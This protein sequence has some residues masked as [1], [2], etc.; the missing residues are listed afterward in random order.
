MGK[1]GNIDKFVKSSKRPA[2]LFPGGL[3]PVEKK[4]VKSI[5]KRLDDKGKQ[6]HEKIF[7]SPSDA[8]TGPQYANFL[9]PGIPSAASSLIDLFPQISQA[10]GGSD[11]RE[12]RSGSRIRLTG[13][14]C[15]FWFHIPTDQPYT[16]DNATMCC[17][18]LVLSSK[19]IRKFSLLES[20]WDAGEL[21]NRKYLRDGAEDTSFLGDM[22]SLHF[23]VNTALFTT[24]YDKKFTL[25]RGQ[26]MGTVANGY[27][28]QV[29]PSKMM[30]INLKVKS[31]K[32]RYPDDSAVEC[33][34]FAPLAIL[35]YAPI[36]GGHTLGTG[37]VVQ[38]NCLIHTT[39]KN[40]D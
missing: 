21:L 36:N 10:G 27:V 28:R 33:D 39:W 40:L 30:N 38:G 15:K 34:N 18:L 2:A 5:A 1:H 32:V 37:G 4:Q 3:K 16:Q 23:P 17:R 11:S 22:K 29:D 7:C 31:T 19:T 24:H 14:R 6:L 20:N 13:V 25:N 9:F 26:L 8:G 35:L 12:Q